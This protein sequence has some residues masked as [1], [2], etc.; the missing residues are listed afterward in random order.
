MT[1]RTRLLPWSTPDGKPCFLVGEGA[2][3]VAR[4]ADSIESVQLG[5]AGDLLGHAAETL[6]NPKATHEE[7]RFMAM[8]LTES[9]RDVR[10]IAES[11]GDRLSALDHPDG[12]GDGRSSSAEANG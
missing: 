4:T 8:R 2:G 6:T 12:D 9:L 5:M 1:D 11:R 7:L 3:F 10:R